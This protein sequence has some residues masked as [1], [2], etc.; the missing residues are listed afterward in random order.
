M[1]KIDL[2][3]ITRSG[4]VSDLSKLGIAVVGEDSTTC[5]DGETASTYRPGASIKCV[6][7]QI[8]PSKQ[9]GG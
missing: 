9:I 5:S 4:L 6:S 7:S 3:V 2:P 1:A 8:L